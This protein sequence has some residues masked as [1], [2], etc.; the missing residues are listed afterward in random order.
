MR[1]LMVVVL[2]LAL[3]F[4]VGFEREAE[5]SFDGRIE[6]ESELESG[7]TA[8]VVNV[9]GHGSV[10][11]VEETVADGDSQE[12]VVAIE[13]A[14]E[15]EPGVGHIKRNMEVLAGAMGEGGHYV[16]MVEAYGGEEGELGMVADVSGDYLDIF[17]V[18]E[19]SMGVYQRHIDL[20]RSDITLTE[21]VEVV[22][23]GK[24]KDSLRFGFDETEDV[25]EE[26]EEDE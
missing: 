23:T 1:Y 12:R 18:A 9:S 26:D 3:P 15:S 13:L 8:S 4:F 22:G 11:A 10:G 19:I 17:K 6:Q 25:E 16:T 20:A 21:V 7:D 14:G 5:Y 2:I 24:L